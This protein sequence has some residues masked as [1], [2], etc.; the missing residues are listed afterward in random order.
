VQDTNEVRRDL[1][2]VWPQIWH[3]LS[4]EAG[5]RFS[6]R[7]NPAGTLQGFREKDLPRGWVLR[8]LF[9]PGCELEHPSSGRLKPF[10]A[11]Q[12]A[13]WD[14]NRLVWAEKGC[15]FAAPLYRETAI[16]PPKL[17][18]NFNDMKFEARAA[19]C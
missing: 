14:R 18:Y 9:A 17:L 11:W 13:E 6:K 5:W 3:A 12:W 16:G 2:D 1:A 19:P 4:A 15:L 10:P 7:M 8:L